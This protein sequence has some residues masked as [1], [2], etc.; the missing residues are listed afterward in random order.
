MSD[1]AA[2]GAQLLAARR[3]HVKLERPL[4]TMETIINCW[5][6]A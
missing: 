2:A 3:V 4:P 6:Q 5:S 1:I